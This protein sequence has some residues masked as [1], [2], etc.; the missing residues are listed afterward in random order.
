[1]PSLLR[2]VLSRLFVEAAEQA[3][4]VMAM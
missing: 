1:V 2:D 4:D 3:I